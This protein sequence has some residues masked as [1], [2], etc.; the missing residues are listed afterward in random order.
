LLNFA[1]KTPHY[2]FHGDPR[3]SGDWT[4]IDDLALGIA[5]ARGYAQATQKTVSFIGIENKP[6]YLCR[7]TQTDG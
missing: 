4:C 6:R 3:R 7:F 1:N 2:C 5:G